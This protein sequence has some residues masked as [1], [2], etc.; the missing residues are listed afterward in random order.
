M[1]E[2]EDFD[3]KIDKYTSDPVL[4]FAQFVQDPSG[5]RIYYAKPTW[6]P[7][8]IVRKTYS[9]YQTDPC[10]TP[11]LIFHLILLATW[12][13]VN[14]SKR[15]LCENGRECTKYQC[16]KDF[17][18]RSPTDFFVKPCRSIFTRPCKCED[19]WKSHFC[20]NSP[21]YKLSSTIND[22]TLPTICICRQFS[23]GG[24]S[25][26][27][28]MTQCY[29]GKKPNEGC[30]CC[31]NQPGPY[32]NQLQCSKGQP[33]FGS[34]SNTTCVCHLPAVYPHYICTDA[35]ED[36]LDDDIIFELSR[37]GDCQTRRE[38]SHVTE[39]RIQ[40]LG[41]EITPAAV[42]IVVLCLL[43][44]VIAMTSLLLVVRS[45]RLQRERRERRMRRN[46]AQSALLQQRAEEDKYLP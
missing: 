30:F 7:A 4:N 41:M 16:D 19:D 15:T 34:K 5:S 32:C 13:T 24:S 37:E 6:I 18:F 43:F 35:L 28:F 3:N 26:Q 45:Y 2:G 21:R 23:D 14:A 46:N 25:C 17:G 38:E 33:E 9:N 40:I 44:G 42:F 27:Q 10:V 36:T 1:L 22:P 8:K 39:K 11:F 29:S 31:F 20:S 12:S